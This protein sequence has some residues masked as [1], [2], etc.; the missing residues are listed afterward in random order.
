MRTMPAIAAAL[1]SVAAA[2][3]V[4]AQTSPS[5]PAPPSPPAIRAPMP[6]MPP[7]GGMRFGSMSE[8]GRKAMHAA[9]HGDGAADRTEHER[10]RAA[11]D[12]ML[13]ALD[14]DRLD[15]AALKRAM[16]DERE[17]ANAM[18]ARRQTALAAALQ[19]LSAADRKA[20]VADAR[21]LRDRIHRRVDRHVMRRT[22]K[23][24][25]MHDEMPVPPT[26][27]EPPR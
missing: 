27:P 25:H 11:R 14:A 12:R 19:S 6:P 15:V 22:M 7:M 4:A 18:K 23:L 3:P 17:A 24:R 5:P 2:L 10:V 8:A 20:F 1:L 16:D 21:G 26:P 13:A 9:M